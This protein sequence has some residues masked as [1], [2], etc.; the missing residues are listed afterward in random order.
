[1]T[2]QR[3]PYSYEETEE[4][5][6]ENYKVAWTF[7]ILALIFG[8]LLMIAYSNSESLKQENTDLKEQCQTNDLVGRQ[9]NWTNES[10]YAP[11][12]K[13]GFSQIELRQYINGTKL[14]RDSTP[15]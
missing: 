11:N 7:I 15:E 4:H 9:V 10:I 8:F 6:K 5:R 13:E 1:M 12:N 2:R 3:F 14:F